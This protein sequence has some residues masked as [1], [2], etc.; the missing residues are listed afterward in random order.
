MYARELAAVVLGSSSIYKCEAILPAATHSRSQRTALT[1]APRRT[2]LPCSDATSHS[3]NIFAVLL[4][5]GLF[6]CCNW[7]LPRFAFLLCFFFYIVAIAT[8]SCDKLF[9]NEFAQSCSSQN[10]LTHARPHPR[11]SAVR[12]GV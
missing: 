12:H 3:P 8:S 7:V 9:A 1:I 6:A 5:H 11:P 10:I 2:R 4:Q